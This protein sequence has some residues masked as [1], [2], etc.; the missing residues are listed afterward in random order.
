MVKKE[1]VDIEKAITISIHLEKSAHLPS[2]PPFATFETDSVFLSSN[3]E[4]LIDI[5]RRAKEYDSKV[6]A[7][8]SKTIRNVFVAG[9]VLAIA[10]LAYIKYGRKLLH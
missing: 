6:Q 4:L 1:A 7:D 10:G 3:F 2:L 9:T 8:R 5:H